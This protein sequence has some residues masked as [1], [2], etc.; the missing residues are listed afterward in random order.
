MRR[1]K[2]L[3]RIKKLL[4][5][6]RGRA[7]EHES[8]A[9]AAAAERLIREYQVAHSEVILDELARG[10]RIT[11]DD[12]GAWRCCPRWQGLLA[13]ATAQLFDCEV[14][15]CDHPELGGHETLRLYGYVADVQVARWTFEYLVAEVER[16][17]ERAWPAAAAP[18][19][20]LWQS[21]SDYRLGALHS[22]VERLEAAAAEKR[23]AEAAATPAGESQALIA[24]AKA[25]AI[26]EL[27]GEIDY[28]SELV[29]VNLGAPYLDGRRAGREI[30][31]R[32]PIARETPEEPALTSSSSS[33][34]SSSD[35]TS[36][37]PP[38]ARSGAAGGS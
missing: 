36:S 18:A 12:I 14:E 17:V 27:F 19:S 4:R 26:R 3:D 38:S 20:T 13:V 16:L 37:S 6:A 28:R 34:S 29:D 31:V 30:A 9:A 7:N 22:L 32:R 35:P 24:R 21:R 15:R 5:V 1:D 11:T 23:A 8:A 10:D 25:A 33:S 2:I